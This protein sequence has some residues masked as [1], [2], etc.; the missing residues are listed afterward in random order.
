MRMR[1]KKVEQTRQ[2]V[3]AEI[4]WANSVVAARPGTGRRPCGGRTRSSAHP[5]RPASGPACASCWSSGRAPRRCPR[6]R[7]GRRGRPRR[8]RAGRFG[9]WSDDSLG[10]IGGTR[11]H[12]EIEGQSRASIPGNRARW[13]RLLVATVTVSP[14]FPMRAAWAARMASAS[15]PSSPAVGRPRR[16]RSAQNSA[17]LRRIGV[18]SGS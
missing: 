7:R 14:G 17:A 10:W 9:P 1:R 11:A 3:P 12:G 13:R 5:G 8:H 15:R 4:A 16:R 2:S 18:V 6:A